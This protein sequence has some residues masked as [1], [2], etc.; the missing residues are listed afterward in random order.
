MYREKWLYYASFSPLWSE[1]IAKHKGVIDKKTKT[2]IFEEQ[3]NSDDNEQAFYDEFGYE[4]DEQKIETQN[5][6][7]Q[8]IKSE[9][10]WVSFYSEHNNNGIIEID[11]DILND[12]GKVIYN[13]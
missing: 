2:V 5:K 1:R 4:P 11:D 12:I 13:F 10:T 7:I 8:E 9:R 6:T 3:E